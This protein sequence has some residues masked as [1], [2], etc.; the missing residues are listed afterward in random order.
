LGYATQFGLE[1]SSNGPVRQS[2]SPKMNHA[3][4]ARNTLGRR[5]RGAVRNSKIGAR[6]F[7]GPQIPAEHVAQRHRPVRRSPIG[8]HPARQKGTSFTTPHLPLGAGHGHC[9]PPLAPV[10]P[11]RPTEYGASMDAEQSQPVAIGGKWVG[12]ENGSDTRKRLPWVATSCRSDRMS[13]RRTPSQ[14]DAPP[15]FIERGSTVREREAVIVPHRLQ[16]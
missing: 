11:I 6:L 7:A 12:P 1:P 15:P 16:E 3:D 4:S 8:T 13:S 5:C 9:P 10:L 14:L 2:D